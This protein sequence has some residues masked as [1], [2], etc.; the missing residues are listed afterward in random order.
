[1]ASSVSAPFCF[2][3]FRP[4]PR[5]SFFVGSNLRPMVL[6]NTKTGDNKRAER[7]RQIA[8][9]QERTLTPSEPR[10]SSPLAPRGLAKPPLHAEPQALG[11]TPQVPLHTSQSKSASHSPSPDLVQTRPK[12][13]L[14]WKRQARSSTCGSARRSDATPRKR[15]A[16]AHCA[17]QGPTSSGLPVR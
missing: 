9:D 12:P 7:E 11:P 13:R 5:F 6:G 2:R 1:M 17:P 8:D 3:A 15:L 10:L 16:Q 14:T 4:G